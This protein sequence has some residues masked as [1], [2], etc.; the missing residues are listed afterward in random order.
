MWPES[1]RKEVLGWGLGDGRLGGP[2][3]ER[4]WDGSVATEGEPDTGVTE[5]GLQRPKSHLV[6]YTTQDKNTHML[7]LYLTWKRGLHHWQCA[8]KT[9]QRSSSKG[10]GRPGFPRRVCSSTLSGP[11]GQESD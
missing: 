1:F 5:E 2:A 9:A 11:G 7:C 6:T 4:R 8:D 3:G 10:H